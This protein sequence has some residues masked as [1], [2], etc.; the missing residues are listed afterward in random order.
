MHPSLASRGAMFGAKLQPD[1]NRKRPLAGAFL[2]G[3]GGLEPPTY[4]L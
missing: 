2:V 3:R 4:G 1:T